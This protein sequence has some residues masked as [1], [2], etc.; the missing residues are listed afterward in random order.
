MTVSAEDIQRAWSDPKLANIIYHDW[1][2]S[3]YDEKWCISYDERCIE[4]A[5]RRFE[6]AFRPVSAPFGTSLEIGAGTGFFTLN[7]MLGDVIGQGHVT[8]LSPR[9]V[10]V[11]LRNGA[12]LDLDVHGKAADAEHLPYDDESFDLV[13]G[14]AVLHHIPDLD[15]AMREVL[16]VL[17]P[18]GVFVFAGEPTARGEFIARGLSRLTW[19]ATKKLTSF[20]PLE[21]RYGRPPTEIAESEREALLEAVVDIH[22][23]EPADLARLCLRAG[24]VDVMTATDELTASWFGWPI[25]TVEAAVRPGSLGRNWYRFAYR[26]W[27]TLNWVDSHVWSAVVPQPFFYNVSVSGTKPA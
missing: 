26:G 7:L 11:A 9:M 6:H 20:G 8:D 25:R 2:A 18:G 24:A 15:L 23:F 22:T 27:T 17:K 5:R 16:R 4:Y 10:E 13:C 14:H 1:E 3:T 19:K 21:H 12:G